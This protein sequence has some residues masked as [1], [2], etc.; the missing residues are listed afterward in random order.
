MSLGTFQIGDRVKLTATFTSEAGALTDPTVCS[1]RIQHPD[2]VIDTYAL[3]DMAKVSLGVW[4]LLYTVTAN[5]P[6]KWWS[7]PRSTAGV[8]AADEEFFEV[9]RSAFATP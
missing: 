7:R 1:W 6:G 8:I 2:G 9:E 3:T 5:T 4:Y